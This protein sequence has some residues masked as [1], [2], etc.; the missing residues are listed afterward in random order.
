MIAPV[1]GMPKIAWEPWPCCQNQ[2]TSAEGGGQRD[3]VE[4]DG[5][6]RE[7]DRAERPHQQQEG[8]HGDDRE[9][10]REV[11]VDGVHVV[12]LD[13]AHAGDPDDAGQA[14]NRVPGVALPTVLAE[15]FRSPSR[16]SR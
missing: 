4:H 7:Q 3:Q 14:G 13:R 11:A 6:E 5:L 9:H 2:V 15:L 16:G 10:E 8:E 1:A 12:E